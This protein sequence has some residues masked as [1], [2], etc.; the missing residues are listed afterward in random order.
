[1][2]NRNVKPEPLKSIKFNPPDIREKIFANGMRLLYSRKS[3]LPIIYSGA[4]INAG[5][6]YDPAGKEGSA[7]LLGMLLDEG[8][9]NYSSLELDDKI[10]FL[11]SSLNINVDS[12][13]LT[14]SMISI[15]ENFE[16]SF[17]LFSQIILI[18]RLEEEDFERQKKI[19]LTKILQ[20][21]DDP[22][23]LC[24]SAFQNIVFSKTPYSHSAIGKTK[25]ILTIDV[26][27]IRNFYKSIFN[28]NETTIVIV[29][30]ISFEKAIEICE[31]NF[32]KWKNSNK[33]HKTFSMNISNNTEGGYYLISKKDAPQS[34]ILLG[35]ILSGRNSKDFYSRTIMNTIL[36][37]QFTSR[38]NSNLRENKGY[39]YGINSTIGYN[40]ER[41]IF[42][43]S[44]SVQ[45][46]VTIDSIR[47][48]INE[49][50]K[51]KDNVSKEEIDFAKSYIIK[52]FPSFFES[53]GQIMKSVFNIAIHNL[54]LDYYNEYSS[55]INKVSREEVIEAALNNIRNDEL[56]FVIVGNPDQF[57]K[58]FDKNFIRIDKE[59]IL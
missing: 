53:G 30:D 19:V 16:E 22:A 28:P 44:S 50:E 56:S 21:K 37:G 2:T 26:E 59:S 7:Y 5:S 49:I 4:V 25:S 6:K 23:L 58:N 40:K 24:K 57:E 39:T 15:T 32:S 14:L 48:I 11:G 47:Q 18:P 27:N 46:E 31:R 12:D 43:I 52:R 38:L 17:D 10:E 34:E 45:S 55:N 41:G 9:G 54:P 33:N 42:S 8:A 51:I 20:I 36:G 29:G 35:H 1:M 13:N 3:N